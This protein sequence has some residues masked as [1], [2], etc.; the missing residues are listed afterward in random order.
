MKKQLPIY[1]VAMLL[2]SCTMQHPASTLDLL[3][4][5]EDESYPA[6]LI[7]DMQSSSEDYKSQLR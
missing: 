4:W 7:E 6:W 3:G 2:F 1:G 5:G